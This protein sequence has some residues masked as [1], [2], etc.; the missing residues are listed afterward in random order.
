MLSCKELLERHLI[1]KQVNN[2]GDI[3]ITSN[4]EM[5][6]IKELEKY[7][8]KRSISLKATR[9]LNI[10]GYSLVNHHNGVYIYCNE[11][12]IKYCPAIYGNRVDKTS[13]CIIVKNNKDSYV[14]LV[15]DRVNKWFTT[16]RGSKNVVN[17]KYEDD[18][19]CAIREVKEET[20]LT[21]EK[22]DLVECGHYEQYFKLHGESFESK[23]VIYFCV[24]TLSDD[25]MKRVESFSNEEIEEIKMVKLCEINEL[26]LKIIYYH[27]VIINHII[28][29]MIGEK[30]K[31]IKYDI[32]RDRLG[33]E[34]FKSF[35]LF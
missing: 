23:C 14:L 34:L 7:D 11:T 9:K 10:V 30:G 24:I 31:R 33:N 8:K 19:D 28:N 21:I 13:V 35:V 6:I 29:K 2:Y 5:E 32:P 17:E 15:K 27:L 20:N 12:A 4:N 1:F 25:E 18:I 22:E 16:I 26:K 3:I